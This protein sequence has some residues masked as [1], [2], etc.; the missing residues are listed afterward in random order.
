[1]REQPRKGAVRQCL[2]AVSMKKGEQIVGHI[3]KNCLAN[4]GDTEGERFVMSLQEGEEMVLCMYILITKQQIIKKLAGL[5]K[6]HLITLFLKVLQR[7][8]Q[9]IQSLNKSALE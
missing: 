3:S 1:M 6:P 8:H 7:S 5:L 9:F 2:L 4:F